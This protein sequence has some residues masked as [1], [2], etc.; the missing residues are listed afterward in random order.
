MKGYSELRLSLLMAAIACVLRPTNIMI[1]GFLGAFALWNCG[2]KR[3]VLVAE[4][5]WIGY[6]IFH[7][8][9]SGLLC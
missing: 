6:D 1:W 5:T 8:E 9:N 7:Y 2:S 3:A 4:A